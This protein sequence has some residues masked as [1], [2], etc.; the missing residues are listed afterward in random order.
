M[1]DD[2]D[3]GKTKLV[4]VVFDISIRHDRSG[5]RIIDVVKDAVKR[6]IMVKPDDILFFVGS[7]QNRI[8][9]S[10]GESV[11]QIDSYNDSPDFRF[12]T[13][14]RHLMGQMIDTVEDVYKTIIVF[15]DRFDKR[16][17]GHYIYPLETKRLR[18][19]EIDIFYIGIGEFYDKE[20]L[21]DE[22]KCKDGNFLH[23][24]SLHEIDDVLKKFEV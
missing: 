20:V 17:K 11:Q 24:N 10:C 18:N 23:L 12:G 7:P 5:N 6:R 1:V 16:Q 3:F 19:L 22:L 15:T 14:I 21:S 9:K 13:T 4:G 8:P 2:F